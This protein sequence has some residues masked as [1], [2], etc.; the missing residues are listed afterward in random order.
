LRDQA[1]KK[2]GQLEQQER[3]IKRSSQKI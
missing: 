2:N 3:Q 1:M